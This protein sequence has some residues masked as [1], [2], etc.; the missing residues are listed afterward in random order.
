M[1]LFSRKKPPATRPQAVAPAIESPRIFE[2]GSDLLDRS[3]RHEKGLLS[4]K[5]YGD[6]LVNWA[7]KDENF[8]TQLFRFVDVFPGLKT[9]EQVHTHVLDYLMRD[10][11]KRPPGF[12]IGMKVG[13][14]AKGLVAST[15]SSQIKSMAGQFIAGE[16]AA[17]ALPTLAKLWKQHVGFSVDLLGE[18]CLTDEEADTYAARYLDLIK[19]L[20]DSAAAW[21][22]DA[23]LERDNVGPVPRVNVSV[24]LSSL[25]ARFNPLDPAGTIADLRPRV[26][27]LL[28][29]AAERGVFVNIDME[30]ST[31]KDVTIA[32]F[33]ALALELPALHAGVVLQAYL[34]SGDADARDLADWAGQNG[35]M[36]TV[37]LVKGAYWDYETIHAEMMGWPAPVWPTKTETDACFERMSGI[38][39][40]AAPRREDAGG[41]KLAL[42]SHNVRSIAAALAG[43]AERGLPESA[44]ELQMLYGMA[45]PVKAAAVERGCRV[46]SYVPVGEMIPGMAYLVRRLLE[47]TSN[48]SWLRAGFID[49]ADRATLLAAPRGE[50]VNG[51]SAS[52]AGS[53]QKR[54]GRGKNEGASRGG[55]GNGGVGGTGGG[56]AGGVDRQKEAQRHGLS[57]AVEGVGDGGPFLTEPWRDFSLA[58]VRQRFAAALAEAVVPKVA[59]DATEADAAKAVA[60]AAGAYE[61]W[62]DVDP[63]ERARVLTRAAA[64]MRRRRDDLSAIVALESGKTWAEADADVCE[65]IDFCEFYA[66]CAPR[67]FTPQRLGRF[68]GELDE[69]F[70]QPRGVAAVIAPW[71][72]PLAICCGMTVAAL[73]CG[74]TVI[75]KPAEQTPGIAKILVDLLHEAGAPA[76]A[77][78]YLPG[79][80]ET[81]GAALVR[82]VR[83]ALI[84]FTGSKQVGFD[85]LQAAGEMRDGQ[86]NVKKAVIEMGGKNAVIVDASADFDEA[87][88]GVRQSA[89]GFQGQKCSACS[90]VIVVDPS[91]DFA[92]NSQST[93]QRF[94]HRLGEATRA[95]D[96][97]DVRDP[98]AQVGPV[99]DADAKAKIER[100][101]AIGRE[102]SRCVVALDVPAGL[103]EQTGR[104]Y[105]GPHVFADV[106]PDSPLWTDE[107][108]GPVVAVMRAASFA[109]ALRVANASPYKLTGGVFSRTPKHLEAARREFRVGNLY[110]NRGI[111]GALVGRQPFGGFGHSGV[112][113]K[114]GSADYLLQ[115][116]EPRAVCEN[117]LRRGFAPAGDEATA[118]VAGTAGM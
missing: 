87:V 13:G 20:A 35:R 19:T 74:N 43:A 103:E 18:A 68:V 88:L 60:T 78:Q 109:D 92:T 110:L 67:L 93:Y 89:F 50:A 6:K 56:G 9:P 114:A 83:V 97:G 30:S 79:P 36:I 25:S 76:A 73:V 15:M 91:D 59:N 1:L 16:D 69:L 27:P 37:R 26:L 72:F 4:A 39:L 49:Q 101:I 21:P 38:L 99:I 53:D 44:V 115:F 96:I 17:E 107:I 41:I 12:D 80:G 62:R 48:E 34:K 33:K 75:V 2:I 46:R 108:F 111:T 54:A 51:G 61:T 112:G 3:A 66:R 10:D 47:N 113:S 52:A 102:S 42:G 100:Y 84:A 90:R 32:A 45:D 116:V 77:L 94:V 63:L 28:Q 55:T 7:M 65:A 8:K 23:L 85:I 14:L 86:A 118:A 11:V 29:A 82:D 5:F 104:L 117:T 22:A 71:N 98:A 58:D 64:A 40:D 105:V 70:H 95:L 81:V 24:K 57:P 106:S 31:Y